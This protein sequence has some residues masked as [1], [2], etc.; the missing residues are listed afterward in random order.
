MDFYTD[1]AGFESIK[2]GEGKL[3]F[4]TFLDLEFKVFDLFIDQADFHIY[5]LAKA[6]LVAQTPMETLFIAPS[7]FST[8]IP[9]SVL[10]HS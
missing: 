4:L 6:S 3:Q 8:G 2:A 5:F 10:I 7:S 9:S 1:F